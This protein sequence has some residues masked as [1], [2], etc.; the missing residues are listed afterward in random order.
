MRAPPP[1]GTGLTKLTPRSPGFP[2][3]VLLLEKVRPTFED[4]AAP[5]HS[6]TSVK[7]PEETFELLKEK[8]TTVPKLGL[9]FHGTLRL[10]L[11]KM[12]SVDYREWEAV[13]PVALAAFR[14]T[15]YD[16]TAFSP[17]FLALGCEIS[18]LLDV[19]LGFPLENSDLHIFTEEYCIRRTRSV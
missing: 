13:L 18:A 10:V 15:V 17:N 1:S 4:T 19:V 7:S 6:L 9:R 14:E 16:G 11:G 12:V 8:L 3:L 2:G 5:L